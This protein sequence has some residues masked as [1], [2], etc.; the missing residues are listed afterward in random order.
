MVFDAID[1]QDGTANVMDVTAPDAGAP[2]ITVRLLAEQSAFPRD[3]HLGIG[4]SDDGICRSRQ[5]GGTEFQGG[6]YAP[7]IYADAADRLDIPA[8]AVLRTM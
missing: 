1:T 6:P 8:G 7:R 2:H 4:L 5:P 3:E